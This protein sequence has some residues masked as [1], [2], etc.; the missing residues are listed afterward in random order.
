[1]VSELSIVLET[2]FNI[3]E[4]NPTLYNVVNELSIVL[5]TPFNIDEINPTLTN[6]NVVSELS[7]V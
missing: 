2:P 3:D 5:E 1:M 7:I 6:Y 4:I